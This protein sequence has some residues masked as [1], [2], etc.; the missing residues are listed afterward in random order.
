MIHVNFGPSFP[1]TKIANNKDV[2]LSMYVYACQ[3]VSQF[4]LAL[5]LMADQ[6]KTTITIQVT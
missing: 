6:R 3:K 4:T 1:S 2:Y 5:L